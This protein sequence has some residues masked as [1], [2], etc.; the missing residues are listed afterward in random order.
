M[1]GASDIVANSLRGIGANKDSAGIADAADELRGIGC[2]DLQMLGRKLVDRLVH[3]GRL[4]DAELRRL[5]LVDV[6]APDAPSGWGAD[7]VG[8]AADLA[9]P[10]A[11]E[12]L[13][14]ERPEV[15]IQLAAVVSGEAASTRVKVPV[16]SYGRRRARPVVSAA[17]TSTSLRPRRRLTG[18]DS[19]GW[20]KTTTRSISSASGPPRSSR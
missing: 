3:D 11:A 2:N 16:T 14:L 10:G 17:H 15:I 13:V 18:R 6:E 4:G 8:L 12:R 9:A 19:V 7:A 5:S 1:I 20:P